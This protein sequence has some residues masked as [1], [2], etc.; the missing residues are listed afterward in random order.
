MPGLP[1]KVEASVYRKGADTLTVVSNL[2][3]EQPATVV[4]PRPAGATCAFDA[5]KGTVL[6][7][8]DGKV[9]VTLPPFRMAIIRWTATATAD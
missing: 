3:D 8:E 9:R 4:L 5:R 2:S 6:A 1:E 7:V